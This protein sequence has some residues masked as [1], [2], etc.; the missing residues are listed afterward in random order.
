MRSVQYTITYRLLWPSFFSLHYAFLLLLLCLFFSHSYL[1]LFQSRALPLSIVCSYVLVFC[2][3]YSV[4]SFEYH[5]LATELTQ[6]NQDFYVSCSMLF[7]YLILFFLVQIRYNI[8]FEMQQHIKSAMH[9]A[10]I[11]F[12]PIFWANLCNH[13]FFHF[14]IVEFVRIKHFINNIFNVVN[15]VDIL[16]MKMMKRIYLILFSLTLF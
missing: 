2:S 4:D 3:E 7:I 5:F 15:V 10:R 1:Y 12:I 13:I 6:N 14:K 11:T 16:C 8:N 9:C